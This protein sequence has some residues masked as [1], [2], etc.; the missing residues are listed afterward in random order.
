MGDGGV[1]APGVEKAAV[2]E[3]GAAGVNVIPDSLA[4][5]VDAPCTSA[6]PRRNIE[7]GVNTPAQEEAVFMAAGVGVFSDDLAIVV[8]AGCLGA[9]GARDVEGGVNAAA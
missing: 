1:S 5:I 9:E 3:A 4:S 6:D 7:G 8:N 2:R